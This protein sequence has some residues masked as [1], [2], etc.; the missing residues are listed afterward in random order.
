MDLKLRL[1]ESNSRLIKLENRLD[2]ERDELINHESLNNNMF[3]NTTH[4]HFLS[5]IERYSGFADDCIKELSHFKS[6]LQEIVNEQKSN[7]I[8]PSAL[9]NEI[10]SDHLSQHTLSTPV[11]NIS[12]TND[13]S[14][15]SMNSKDVAVSYPGNDSVDDSEQEEEEKE[16]EKVLTIP[17]LSKNTK[18]VRAKIVNNLR[19]KYGGKGFDV[20]RKNGKRAIYTSTT[21]LCF[22]TFGADTAGIDK[23][24]KY[25]NKKGGLRMYSIQNI[26]RWSSNKIDI[27]HWETFCSEHIDNI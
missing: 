11:S 22:K 18:V 7:L 15:S 21:L 27:Q 10:I 19:Y 13:D 1:R 4:F 6:L 23:L 26:T 20:W 17:S 14:K 5:S 8:P 9:N 3:N 2:S 24:Q 25:L 12:Y 16:N